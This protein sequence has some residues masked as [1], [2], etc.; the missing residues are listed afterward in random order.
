MSVA[1]TTNDK[2]GMNKATSI[3]IAL[4]VLGA[5]REWLGSGTLFSELHTLW[6]GTDTTIQMHANPP[7]P[8]A[9]Y[10]PGAF[11]IAGLVLALGQ[12]VLTKHADAETNKPPA[13]NG[14][15]IQ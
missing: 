7:L 13:H 9:R 11:I 2:L 5:T 12:A 15:K 10:A 3:A 14:D 1:G 4:I 8:L 6:N